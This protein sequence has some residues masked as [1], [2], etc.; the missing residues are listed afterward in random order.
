MQGISHA[1]G[2]Y[3]EVLVKAAIA[4]VVFRLGA[5]EVYLT[6]DVRAEADR[7]HPTK[8]FRPIAAGLVPQSLACTFALV[9]APHAEPCFCPPVAG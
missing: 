3:G 8:R 5:S 2:A 7:Q 9:R 1:I 4:F 6:N